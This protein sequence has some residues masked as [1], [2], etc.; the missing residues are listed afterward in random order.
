MEKL[1]DTL[2]NSYIYN[3]GYIINWILHQMFMMYN[4]ENSGAG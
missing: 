2:G 1:T 4:I 3:N